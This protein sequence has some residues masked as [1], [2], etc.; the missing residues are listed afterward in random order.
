MEMRLQGIGMVA[1]VEAGTIKVGDI[2]RW[3]FGGL[4]RVTSVDFTKT[5]KT[6]IVG[7]EYINHKGEVVQ[8][9]RKMRIT[10]GVNII[11]S[12][13]TEL[14]GEKT[15]KVLEPVA[16]KVDPKEEVAA[17]VEEKLEKAARSPK[18]RKS[19]AQKYLELFF[20]EKEVPYESW[21]I[22]AFEETHYIDTDFIIAAIKEAPKSEQ[23]EIVH[24]LRRIDFVNGNVNHF[25]KFLA[26]A[27]V[28]NYYN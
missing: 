1:A 6:I 26:E 15:F 14:T 2:L 11:A 27:Y 4:E 12:G 20:D 23:D 5:G 28:Q 13:E 19:A 9:E 21:E 24:T 10:R 16:E 7:I 18:A 22:E 17:T 8:S 3:N 25:L